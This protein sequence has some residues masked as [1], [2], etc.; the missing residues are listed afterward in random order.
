M[1]RYGKHVRESC[2]SKCGYCIPLP[3]ST[4]LMRVLSPMAVMEE[5]AWLQADRKRSTGGEVAKQQARSLTTGMRRPGSKRTRRM[6][7]PTAYSD[8][9]RTA[10]NLLP[11]KTRSTLQSMASAP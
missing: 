5:A 7:T 3:T 8:A 11:M 1:L 9:T 6:A 10:S 4:V 2:V